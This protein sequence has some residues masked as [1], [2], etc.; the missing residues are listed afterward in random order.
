MATH[1]STLASKISW[2][3]ES[4]G[5][6]SMESQRVVDNWATSLSC[7]GEG[8]GNPHQCFCLENPRDRGAWCA[9]VH[10]VTQSGHGFSDLADALF[11]FFCSFALLC[12]FEVV[13]SWR[14]YGLISGGKDFHRTT[15]LEIIRI[16]LCYFSIIVYYKIL[17]MHIIIYERIYCLH[18]TYIICLHITRIYCLPLFSTMGGC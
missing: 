4:G 10:G 11:L 6:Q 9:A 13:A 1:S 18:I 15:K 16:Y 2:M 8:N 5:L 12:A 14:L 3:E 17:N 7:I